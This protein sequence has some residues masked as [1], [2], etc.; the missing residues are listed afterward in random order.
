MYPYVPGPV[1]INRAPW[2]NSLRELYNYAYAVGLGL[3]QGLATPE[4]HPDE[5]LSGGVT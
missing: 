4:Q 1:F 2:L 5:A 3:K